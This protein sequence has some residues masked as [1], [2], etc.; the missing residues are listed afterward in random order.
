MA[1]CMTNSNTILRSTKNGRVYGYKLNMGLIVRI[2][3]EIRRPAQKELDLQSADFKRGWPT[4]RVRGPLTLYISFFFWPLCIVIC[5][6]S[7]ES[8]VLVHTFASTYAI[9]QKDL[10][11][12]RARKNRV[13]KSLTNFNLSRWRFIGRLA[14][15]VQELC[16]TV[17]LAFESYVQLRNLWSLSGLISN[18]MF[19]L[20]SGD[21][22]TRFRY[23]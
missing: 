1:V 10:S 20:K 14:R 9:N 16:A 4:C 3:Y 17:G 23:L 12:S 7:L 11:N 18:S 8:G 13:H 2:F 19:K 5:F 21:N 15:Y 22:K 6:F